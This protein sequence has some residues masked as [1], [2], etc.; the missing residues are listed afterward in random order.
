[1]ILEI[2]AAAAQP[3]LELQ[4]TPKPKPKQTKTKAKLKTYGKGQ[5]RPYQ[6]VG[7]T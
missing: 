6:G 3:V 7:I 2:L 1:M 4:I 5:E